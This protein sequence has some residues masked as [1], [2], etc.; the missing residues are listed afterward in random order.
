MRERALNIVS[1]PDGDEVRKCFGTIGAY[2]YGTR[3]NAA[4]VRESK[5][6]ELDSGHDDRPRAQNQAAGGGSE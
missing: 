1:D 3:M 5:T 4:T 2:N 6:D